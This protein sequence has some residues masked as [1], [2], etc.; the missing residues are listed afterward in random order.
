M[1]EATGSA[2]GR[3]GCATH[4]PR[5][6][7]AP[8]LVPG[9][10][11]VVLG[12]IAVGAVP[13][14]VN[15]LATV[16]ALVFLCYFVRHAAF[17]VTAV[18]GAPVDLVAPTVRPGD[19]P[20]VTVLVACRDEVTVV[21]GLVDALDRLTYPIDRL[22]VVIVDDGS[23]DGTAELLDALVAPRPRCTVVHRPVGAAGGKAAALNAALASADGD[24]FAVFD[25]DHRPAPDGV[26]R[27]VRALD[28]PG[29]AVAQ[30]RCIIRNAGS[31][32]ISRAVALDYFS[33]Y[34]VDEYGRQALIGLPACGGANYAVRATDV[35]ALGGWNATSVTEDTDLTTRLLLAGRR[36]RYDVTATDTE[37]AVT[38]LRRY[39]TQRY[40]W[41]RGHQAVCRTYRRAVLGAPHLSPGE[42]LEALCF[43]HAY[44]VPVLAA[45]GFVFLGLWAG[46][47][48]TPLPVLGVSVL[49]T[50][51]FLG[52]LVE[53]GAGLMVA[54]AARRD[55]W[56]IVVFL[57]LFVLSVLV[58][59]KAWIDGLL[60]RPYA[61]VKTARAADPVAA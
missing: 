17:A 16:T 28:D 35:R 8:W 31:S 12:C 10:A 18:R 33:G 51:L 41:A 45:G 59:T 14:L 11:G 37:E 48:V 25:A 23:T 57:P 13:L 7:A 26:D 30:G 29:V 43:L 38:T 19:L 3:A 22:A 20:Q 58:S 4:T 53:L 42:R 47:V 50:L 5:G 15:G 6:T 56:V 55:A 32:L 39:W 49:W 2:T 40:R 34:L 24:V 9:A 21:G 1:P 61:W 36:I 54:G 46:G 60:G 52:P 44:H 27:L